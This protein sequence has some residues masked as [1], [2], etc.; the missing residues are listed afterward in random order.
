MSATN[1]FAL[2]D[3]NLFACGSYISLKDKIEFYYENPDIKDSD[4]S[5]YID[6]A[7]Q[8]QID[9]CVKQ[10]ENVFSLAIKENK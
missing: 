4:S 6:Y 5:K 9:N 8:Y 3:R 10:L 2:N 7:K 1:Q